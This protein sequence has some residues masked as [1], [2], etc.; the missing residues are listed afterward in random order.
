MT[1]EHDP[2]LDQITRRLEA[3]RPVPHP[4]YRGELRRTLLARLEHR[5][6]PVRVRR[7]IAA[8]AGSGLCLLAVAA[9]GVAGAGPLAA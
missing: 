3:E 1:D 4:A 9:L 2:A 7:L 8:Y 5:G 6:R